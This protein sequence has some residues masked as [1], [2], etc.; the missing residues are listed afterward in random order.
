MCEKGIGNETAGLAVPSSAIRAVARAEPTTSQPSGAAIANG[1]EDKPGTWRPLTGSRRVPD[2]SMRAYVA[3]VW[4][5]SHD[6][7]Q[8]PPDR[9]ICWL[10]AVALPLRV[11]NATSAPEAVSAAS[12]RCAK[13]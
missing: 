9:V 12:K 11:A 6:T 1:R 4:E 2:A 8:M 13:S 10:R 3:P 7:S 5:S